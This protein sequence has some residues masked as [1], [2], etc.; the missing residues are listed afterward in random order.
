MPEFSIEQERY[1][2]FEGPAYHFT[3]DRRDFLKLLG[4]GIL[5]LLMLEPEEA[6]AQES[7]GRARGGRGGGGQAMPENLGAWLHVREDGG[8]TVYT[9]KVE[10]GQNARTSLVAGVAEELRLDPKHIELIMGDTQL[11]PYDMGTFGSQ[12]T[13]RMAPQIHKV[14]AVAREML[15]DLAA[16]QMKADRS[17][18]KVEN[19]YVVNPTGKKLSFGELSKGQE[20]SRTISADAPVTPATA[21]K[22]LGHDLT[23]VN[24]RD[25]VTGRH[26]YTQD[27]VR[28]GMLYGRIVRPPAY[29]AKLQ[30]ADVSAAEKI[31]GVTVVH[32][33]DFLGIAC[34]D[35]SKLAPA[36][37]AIKAQWSS[38]N[39]QPNSNTVEKGDTDTW[40]LR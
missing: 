32:D 21:W 35:S 19:G 29:T 3:P 14:A 10:V 38:P 27:V 9:G 8:V 22:T 6:E 36:A 28:P 26:R 18:L 24:G 15:V 12:T 37:A 40:F 2:L 7:G 5:V 33:G 25:I 16:Q 4:G 31:A 34:A 13:P 17:A 11:V 30:S 1:E 23:K 20:L 39:P